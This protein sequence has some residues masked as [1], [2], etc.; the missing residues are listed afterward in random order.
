MKLSA[1]V[2][3][4]FIFVAACSTENEIISADEHHIAIKLRRSPS[5]TFDPVP[6]AEPT[7]K[8]HCA[9]HGKTPVDVS[10]PGRRFGEQMSFGGRYVVVT[11][12]C[13]EGAS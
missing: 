13:S 7:A 1:L 8:K 6:A 2:A 4:V 11:F 12:A 5:S 3:T 10:V 9:K